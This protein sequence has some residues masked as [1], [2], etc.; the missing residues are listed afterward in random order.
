[1]YL[2]SKTLT[3]FE[4]AGLHQHFCLAD[5]HAYQ[6]LH[7]SFLNIIQSLPQIWHK[8]ASQSIPST[9]QMFNS[10]FAKLINAPVL[11]NFNCNF[12]ICPTASNSIDI[13]GAVLHVLK[14]SVVMIEP[15]F[16]NLALLMK[17]RGVDLHSV[18]DVDLFN[19]AEENEIEYRLPHLKKYQALVLVHPNNPT[20][21]TLSEKAFENIISFCK[22]HHIALIID[23][24]FRIYRRETYC[25]YKILIESSIPFITLEDTGKVWPTQD[26]KASLLYFSEHFKSVISEIYNEIYLCVSNFALGVLSAF[27]DVT[28]YTGIQETIW[29]IVDTRREALR[30]VIKHSV[31]SIAPHAINSKLPVEWL[32]CL[33]DNLDDIQICNEL[34]SL[35]L[36]I[37][38]GRQFYWN[39]SQF[40]FH[41]KN[42]RVS[43]MKPETIF[44]SG[45]Q[46]LQ[47]YSHSL[48]QTTIKDRQ[49]LLQA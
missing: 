4:E 34:K 39:S 25:D 18:K 28:A 13:I 24:C 6:D 44:T 48:N 2:I 35:N 47:N 20:G 11:E 17:R 19:A 8:M 9:A 31:L 27:F 1:M 41:H 33:Q 7:P 42:I 37:L 30:N 5:G 49:E 12:K 21:L 43:L 46:I 3:D 10:S 45:L 23:N 40:P 15:A 22:T 29:N 36:A 14:Y 16:D 32:F 38:P 26:L